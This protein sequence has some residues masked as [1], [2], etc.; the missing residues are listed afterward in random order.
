MTGTVF[1]LMFGVCLFLCGC[2]CDRDG[3][4]ADGK[5]G[6]K[7]AAQ[8]PPKPMLDGWKKPAVAIVLS[9]EL[10]GYLEPC[11]CSA[12]QSGGLSRRADLFRQLAA[13]D[14]PVT[15]VD[16]G[17]LVKR[18][19][20]QSR[21]KFETIGQDYTEIGYRAIGLGP[22]ELRLGADYLI[23]RQPPEPDAAGSPPLLISANLI[24]YGTPDLGV[25]ARFRV[26]DVGGKS[27][28]VTAVFGKSLKDNVFLRGAQ[29]DITFVDPVKSLATVID[30]LKKRKVDLLV[31]LAQAELKESREL[32][33]RFP[34]LN[35]ILSAGGPEDP[36]GKPEQIGR[37]MLVTTGHKGKYVGIVSFYPDDAKTPLR[38]EL[39]DLDKFR[40][41]NTPGIDNR[42]REYQKRLA[43][44]ASQVMKDVP[45]GPHPSGSRFTGVETCRRCHTKAYAV[46]KT[47]KHAQAYE[48]LKTGRKDQKTRW[49]SRIRDPECLACHV[50]GWN[51]ELLS[52]YD[53]GFMIQE[54]SGD[55][56]Q[57]YSLL[58]GQQCENCHGP[59]SRHVELE[60][61]WNQD[62]SKTTLEAVVALRKQVHRSKETAERMVCARCH[63]LENSPHFDFQKY[64]KDVE[65][66]GRD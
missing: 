27:I 14:W 33:R 62:R 30:E 32:A 6:G 58:Q 48:S 28:G 12:T 47:T 54:L 59:G 23:S 56:P 60:T 11:G 29:G 46:W 24:F 38:F 22:E 16:L 31:L 5:T 40:F 39:V 42:M 3:P 66:K 19:R 61:L 10:H 9:G 13:R 18:T 34:E 1:V 51:P 15:A 43:D 2:G 63:D 20:V 35:L 64:W 49:I 17:G 25:P 44:F 45:S 55:H 57:R 37:T 4:S 26:I 7:V 52:R 50:V 36:D 8:P 65:H 53:S 21:Y 41:Q